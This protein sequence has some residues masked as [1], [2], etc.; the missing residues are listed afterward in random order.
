MCHSWLFLCISSFSLF[1]FQ[2]LRNQPPLRTLWSGF[3]QGRRSLPSPAGDS[4]HLS[5]LAWV[6]V[7]SGPVHVIL[8][9]QGSAAPT[10]SSS[11]RLQ[12]STV[13]GV[14]LLFGCGT[15]SSRAWLMS[16][17][18]GCPNCLLSSNNTLSF[19][20]NIDEML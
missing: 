3:I 9:L 16:L 20:C 13:R 11:R 6:R 14:H 12:Q 4:G 7:P 10:T 1:G 15:A 17:F 18:S 8:C 5:S 2:H 19:H